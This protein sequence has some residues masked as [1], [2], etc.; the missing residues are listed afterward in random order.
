MDTRQVGQG[1]GRRRGQAGLKPRAQNGLGLDARLCDL[2]ARCT[3]QDILQTVWCLE[4]FSG[5][6]PLPVGS[7]RE[8]SAFVGALS[9]DLH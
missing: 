4:I 9:I 7:V 6:V 1:L 3:G 8:L 5:K 2:R